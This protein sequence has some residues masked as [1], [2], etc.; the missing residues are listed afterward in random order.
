MH[1]ALEE[2]SV[3]G[4]PRQRLAFRVDVH[5]DEPVARHDPLAVPDLLLERGRPLTD[6]DHPAAYDV[7]LRAEVHLT[8][9]VDLATCDHG[10]DPA[11]D[12]A[13]WKTPTRRSTCATWA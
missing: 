2:L 12:P 7:R 4:V 5:L 6:G 3:G 13:S 1:T 11:V 8:D 9:V 10:V